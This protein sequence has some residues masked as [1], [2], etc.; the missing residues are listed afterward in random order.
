VISQDDE[1]RESFL[2]RI[3]GILPKAHFLVDM[4]AV[5][6]SSSL[7]LRTGEVLIDAVMNRVILRGPKFLTTRGLNGNT[8]GKSINQECPPPDLLSDP[9]QDFSFFL[10][11]SVSIFTCRW[12]LCSSFR[13]K[14]LYPNVVQ[15]L[16]AQM[17]RFSLRPITQFF[18]EAL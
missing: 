18:Y 8:F 15:L 2:D 5:R 4:V 16:L 10:I 7:F 12:A 3:G 17:A 13:M 11:P 6:Q 1:D 14:N 9:F